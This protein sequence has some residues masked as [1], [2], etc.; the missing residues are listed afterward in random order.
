MHVFPS[1]HTMLSFPGVPTHVGCPLT[2]VQASLFVHTLLS[3]QAVPIGAVPDPA[4]QMP[5]LLQVSPVVHVF[6]SHST[7]PAFAVPGMHRV[8]AFPLGSFPIVTHLSLIVQAL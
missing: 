4:V 7:A 6:P 8:T 5:A 2:T 3:S 1:L